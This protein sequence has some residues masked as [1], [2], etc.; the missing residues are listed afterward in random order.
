M[1][2]KKRKQNNKEKI[3]NRALGKKKFDKVLEKLLKTPP[4]SKN[5]KKN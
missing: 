2:K 5:K 4:E 1:K 3:G